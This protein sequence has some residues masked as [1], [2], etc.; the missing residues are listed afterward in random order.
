MLSTVSPVLAVEK[1]DDLRNQKATNSPR[2]NAPRTATTSPTI[3]PRSC[4]N[5]E[6]AIKQQLDHLVQL[7]T[8]MQIKFDRISQRTQ[9]YY[10]SK[11]V[12]NGKSVP[13]Y[14]QLVSDIQTKKTAVQTAVNTVK[15]DVADFNCTSNPKNLLR[16]FHTDM[17]AVKQALKDYRTSIKNLIVA[18]RSV[19][20]ENE[21]NATKT[22]SPKNREKQ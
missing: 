18:V 6:K 19:T 20:G 4:Q 17:Q 14:N 13:N 11:V 12:P 1:P 2:L 3:N 15:S 8:N 16:K 5:R 22:A 10:S 21:K 7:A 9:D